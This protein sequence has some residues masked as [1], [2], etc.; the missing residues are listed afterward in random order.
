M[1][2]AL[3]EEQRWDN[4]KESVRSFKNQLEGKMDTHQL[5]DV[6]NIPSKWPNDRKNPSKIDMVDLFSM[7]RLSKGQVQEILNFI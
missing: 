3:E 5:R 1:I 7:N 6:F 4:S 2:A